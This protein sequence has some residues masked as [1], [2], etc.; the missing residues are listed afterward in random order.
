[1]CH[2]RQKINISHWLLYE[3]RNKVWC[4]LTNPWKW[5]WD[6]TGINRSHCV[7]IPIPVLIQIQFQFPFPWKSHG[8]PIPMGTPI[9]MHSAHLYHRGLKTGISGLP[10]HL[11]I[12]CQ[13]ISHCNVNWTIVTASYFDF[14]PTSSS[15]SSL[16]R[17]L[18]H[19]SSLES[20]DQS[21]I[22]PALISLHW[23]RVP[24]RISFKL[25]VLTYRSIHGTSP[26]YIQSCFARVAGITSRRRLRFSASHRLE[27]PPVRLSTVGKRAFPVAGANMWN[28]LPLHVTSAQSLLVFRQRLKTCLHTHYPDMTYRN[29]VFFRHSLWT[30]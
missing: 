30:L 20:D 28:D 23:L 5:F 22:T 25:A 7:P 27:V 18:L 19:C 24:E 26:S 17:T 16:F 29:V 13:K 6:S 1:M 10:L 9:P 4:D 15:A 3:S 21:I 12:V 8:N 2:R 14:L 11:T